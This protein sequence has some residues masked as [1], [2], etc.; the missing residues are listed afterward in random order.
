MLSGYLLFSLEIVVP[1]G[2][3]LF[4]GESSFPPLTLGQQPKTEAKNEQ[5]VVSAEADGDS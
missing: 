2:G 1:D 4:P 5:S 3:A